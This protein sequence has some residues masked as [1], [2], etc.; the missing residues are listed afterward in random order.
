[1][2]KNIIYY[3]KMTQVGQKVII[4][5]LQLVILCCCLFCCIAF[6]SNFIWTIIYIYMCFDFY[7][8]ACEYMCCWLQKGSL[9]QHNIVGAWD[10][11]TF[12]EI[13][14]FKTWHEVIFKK[15]M[16]NSQKYKNVSLKITINVCD[17]FLTRAKIASHKYNLWKRPQGNLT[18]TGDNEWRFSIR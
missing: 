18:F 13:C 15:C 3:F 7:D 16:G 9:W 5:T 14:H 2:C 11:F 17:G 12:I 4:K 6:I 10:R 1:M 8:K